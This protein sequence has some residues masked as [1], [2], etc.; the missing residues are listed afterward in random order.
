[1]FLRYF[2]IC[3]YQT[4]GSDI[5]WYTGKYYP[6]PVAV[7]CCCSQYQGHSLFN[8]YPLPIHSMVVWG[9]HGQCWAINQ[10]SFNW[11]YRILAWFTWCVKHQ[12]LSS[13]SR[14]SY[15]NSSINIQYIT[16]TL[17]ESLLYTFL[18]SSHC[19]VSSAVTEDSNNGSSAVS[20]QAGAEDLKRRV[21]PESS[22]P[23][24]A[25][26]THSSEERDS[27]NSVGEPQTTAPTDASERSV[28]SELPKQ[29][30]LVYINCVLLF[31][32]VSLWPLEGVEIPQLVVL[33]LL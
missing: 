17:L 16:I 2:Y 33:V 23:E 1:M 13:T 3:F 30:T 7:F 8:H 5:V 21:V 27:V 20:E 29:D 6:T 11:V 24:P 10:D 12:I 32:M 19:P 14:H 31:L 28:G 18:F 25:G 4:C 22:G 15:Q 26:F 9:G